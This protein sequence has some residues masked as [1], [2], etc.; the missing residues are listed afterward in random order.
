[1]LALKELQRLRKA[2]RYDAARP[3]TD[4][5][6]QPD[7]QQVGDSSGG[8]NITVDN[9]TKPNL[10]N[11]E[12]VIFGAAGT[13]TA[14]TTKTGNLLHPT[15]VPMT[16]RSKDHL[17]TNSIGQNCICHRPKMAIYCTACDNFSY[18]RIQLEC[19]QH[20]HVSAAIILYY[21]INLKLK[22]SL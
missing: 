2:V 4:I 1:M 11:K 10:D 13:T 9:K 15:N 18:G 8:S 16:N 20:P 17:R 7:Q 3:L 6:N 5:S 14:T 12:Y 19:P 21:L 22:K